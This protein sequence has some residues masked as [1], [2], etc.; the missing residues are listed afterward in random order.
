MRMQSNRFARKIVPI[1]AQSGVAR[2]RRLM[3]EAFARTEALMNE[4]SADPNLFSAVDVPTFIAS[5]Q[6]LRWMVL[7]V[8]ASAVDA[9]I[10]EL[11]P[12]MEYREF[13]RTGWRIFTIS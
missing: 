7:M 2:L 4:H 12:N 11:Q 10:Q 6:S 9:V 13:G 8:Q 1:L 5:L 3:R